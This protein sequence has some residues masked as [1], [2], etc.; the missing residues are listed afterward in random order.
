[1]ATSPP[2]IH[3]T[4][5]SV[6]HLRQEYA[7]NIRKGGVFAPHADPLPDRSECA[8]ILTHPGTG[9]QFEL[10]AEV[11]YVK[12]ED[13][14]RGVGV[15]LLDFNP[16]IVAALEAFIES[17]G[18]PAAAAPAAPSESEPEPGSQQ[19]GDDTTSDAITE[20]EETRA[21][22]GGQ[23]PKLAVSALH[24]RLRG[25]S[26]AEQMKL[27]R[28]GGLQER[29]ALE[30]LFGKSVW[31]PILQNQRVSPPEVARIARMGMAPAPLLETITGNAAWLSSGEVRRALLSNPRLSDDGVMK[32]LRHAP[33]SELQLVAAQTIYP[34]RVRK[35]ARTLLNR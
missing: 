13:P 28:E 23:P 1:M 9:G 3:V 16:A 22:Q 21:D 33:K 20:S 17:G 15:H 29:V 34:T 8:L 5:A 25:L 12:H 14:G 18:A 19:Q 10:R 4:F 26:I 30:R 6:E 35:I 32:V 31:E 24:E 2:G 27:A 7:R 11:V